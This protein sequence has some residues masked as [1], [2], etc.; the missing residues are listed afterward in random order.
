MAYH[1]PPIIPPAAI[2]SLIIAMSATNIVANTVKPVENTKT[3]Q[4]SFVSSSS[5]TTGSTS[6]MNTSEPE[7][8]SESESSS[9][10][11]ST[12]QS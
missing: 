1:T 2:I 3:E 7:S 12:V 9:T 8:E 4:S 5:A 10:S 6:S 11:E